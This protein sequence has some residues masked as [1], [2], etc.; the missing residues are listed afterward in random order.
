MLGIVDYG[1]GNLFA[2]QSIYKLLGVPHMF[3]R[4]REHFDLCSHIVLP[5]VGDYDE[6]LRL[7]SENGFMEILH[8][9]VL[10]ERKFF[11][12]VCVGMQILGSRSEEGSLPGLNW[13]SGSVSKISAEGGEGLVRLPHMGWNSLNL[14]RQSKLMDGID[15]DK[16]AYFLHNY[17]F[18][19]DDPECVISTVDYS[20][21]ITS[22]INKDNMYGVQFHPEKS[23][24][25]GVLLLK[26]FADL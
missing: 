9:C 26:N 12:G 7:L 1:S 17:E 13:I 19:A 16:G 6:T 10:Q 11:L 15:L 3:I 8:K 25:N 18:I 23:L 24:S 5:G 4:S 20:K 22:I 14:I 2:F 21:K